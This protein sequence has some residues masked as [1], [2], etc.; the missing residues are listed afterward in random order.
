M[1]VALAAL[2]TAF[3]G[4][5]IALIQRGVNKA[6]EVEATAKE[7]AAIAVKS[8]EEA[9]RRLSAIER[10]TATNGSKKTLGEITEL[11]YEDL[12]QTK[13]EL[14]EHQR[15]VDAHGLQPPWERRS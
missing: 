2:I 4:V 9:G 12:Q 10:Q 1:E 11:M 13:R 7:A 3:G 15:R 14:A 8:A 5:I 6:A